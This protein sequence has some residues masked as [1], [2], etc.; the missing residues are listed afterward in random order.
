LG[1]SV[2]DWVE[3]KNHK[4]S[5]GRTVNKLV[6][7]EKIN[8]NTLEISIN[9]TTDGLDAQGLKLVR[10]E[11]SAEDIPLSSSFVQIE[12]GVE[13]NF[14]AGTYRTGD[15]WLIPARTIDSS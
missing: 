6:Q 1:F 12:D 15:Y 2:G 9:G 11:Q 8:R 13:V 5:L 4:T 10:W 3:F 14:S 7:I